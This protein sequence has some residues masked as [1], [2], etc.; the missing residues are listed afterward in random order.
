[1]LNV[2][3]ILIQ[4][5]LQTTF[6]LSDVVI[7]ELPW[8]CASL[9]HDRLLQLINGVKLSAVVD[10]LLHGPKWRSLP[11]LNPSCW[12]TCLVQCRRHSSPQVRDSVS[13][14]VRWR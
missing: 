14:N 1:M 10:S 3:V 2:S 6:S 13:R 7:N 9:Q 4:D 12:G 11:N 5:T 8:Q